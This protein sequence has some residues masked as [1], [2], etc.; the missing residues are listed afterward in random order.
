VVLG[1]LQVFLITVI[2]QAGKMGAVTI[3]TNMAGRGVDIV[4]GGN[5]VEEGK[6]KK[7]IELGGVHVIGTERHEARRIDNQLRGRSGRQ[8]D[9]GSSQ[10][11]VSLEDDLIRVFGGE[12]IKSLME[13]LKIPDNQPI[14]A[15]MVSKAIESAQ[16][17]IE[18][19][20]FDLRK[21]ILE[22]D[23][24]M[25]KHRQV[26]YKKRREILG[27]SKISLR[28][29]VLELVK[30]AGFL[31]ED[32]QKKEKEVGEENMRQVE[33]FVCLRVLDSF[34]KEH[35]EN[36]ERLRDSVRLRAYGQQDPLVEYKREGH[37]MFQQLLGMIESTIANAIF[38]AELKPQ[39][40]RPPQRFQP[41][42]NQPESA[43]IGKN[44]R[45]ERKPGRNDP[46]P[47]GKINPRTG[48][49]MKYK[50][51]CWPKYG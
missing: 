17:K 43:K 33:K 48:K 24:V 42:F 26:F 32:Y 31:Q 35:L 34:W 1:Y 6:Q 14:E 2:A 13:T 11:F 40:Q 10:F 22:Y 30:K 36:M 29:H 45:V 37:K 50:K 5:P 41:R 3:A 19:M 7:V 39:T 23:D 16:S 46:C 47:C 4:L 18:G 51:C 21:H 38:K 49:P 15:R 8:G 28:D 20:N 25:N 27:K 12:R 44:Q 9:P